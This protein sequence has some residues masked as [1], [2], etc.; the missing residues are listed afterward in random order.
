MKAVQMVAQGAPEVLRTVEL[1][2]P[3]PGPGEVLIK[4][5]AA[6][7]NYSDVARRRG[8]LYPFPT[9]LPF[10]PGGEVAGVVV[11]LGDGVQAPTVGT[12]VFGLV[13]VDGR[14][15]YAELAVAGATNVAP[16]PPGVEPAQAA[17]VVIA[18]VTA[19]LLLTDVA[20][21]GPDTVL[22][23]PG[24]A[25]GVGSFAVQIAKILGVRSVIA[26]AG[27]ESKRQRAIGLGADHVV[28]PTDP[29]WVT[30]VL[31]LTDGRGVDVALEAAGGASLDRTLMTLAPFGTAVV[32]GMA[33]G[34]PG[35]ISQSTLEHLL[36]RPSLSP[37]LAV[38][39]LG[40]HFGLRPD[41]AGAALGRLIGWIVAGELTVDVTRTFSLEQA[42]QAH[43][44]M[45]SRASTGKIVL[46]P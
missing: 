9:D 4:V 2:D 20:P 6:A 8:T 15:G 18:G 42:E 39:N 27:S 12:A 43:R 23:I 25:G 21:V 7:V 46:E 35:R 36:Y 26:S 29:D 14:G 41:V 44:L 40:L 31:D 1:A 11:A 5:Q 33:G 24:A 37:T 10:V 32:Y 3:V 28:D 38:F 30:K 45:E 22:L 13:G 34:E 16:I 17:G 19:T